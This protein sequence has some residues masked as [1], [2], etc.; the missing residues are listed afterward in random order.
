MGELESG[1]CG[2]QGEAWNLGRAIVSQEMAR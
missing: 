2:M 1:G